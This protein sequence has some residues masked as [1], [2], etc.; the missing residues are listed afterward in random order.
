MIAIQFLME[1][2]LRS[3]ILILCGAAVLRALRVKDASIRMAAWTAMLFGS[4]AIPALTVMLPDMSLIIPRA[5]AA[6][7]QIPRAV[8]ETLPKSPLAQDAGFA[9]RSPIIAKPFD[10][11]SAALLIYAAVAGAFL[12]RLCLG[13]LLSLRLLRDSRPAGLA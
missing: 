6:P 3:S 8:N 1:W 7:L 5:A 13:L 10:W 9:K 2:A 11:A 12:L 4:L